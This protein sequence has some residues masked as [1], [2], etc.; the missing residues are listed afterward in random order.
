M[1]TIQLVAGIGCVVAA[2]PVLA[3]GWKLSAWASATETYT[4]NVNFSARS[5]AESDFVTSISAGLNIAGEGGGKRLKLNGSVGLAQNLYIGRAQDNSFAPNAN[6]SAK[7]EA[8]ENFAFVDAQAFVSQTFQSPFGA[9][10]TNT[11]TATENRYTQQTYAVSP[12]IKGVFPSSNISYQ[13]RDDNYWTFAS[14][15]GDSSTNI[16]ST[17]ANNL[18]VSM[19]S[20]VN[21]WGWTLSYTR[22]YFDNGVRNDRDIAT[23][24]TTYNNLLGTLIYQIDPQLQLSLRAGFQSYKFVGPS[25]EE[26]RYGIGFQWSPTDRTQV[27]GFWDHTFYGSSYSLQISHRL[28]NA[29]LSAN[30]SR[31]LS[32]FPQL[33]LA[34]PAGA[35]VNQFLNA[36]FATRIPD[37][38]ERTQAVDQFLART[39]LPPTLASPVNFYATTLTLQEAANL[40]LVLLGMRN[41]VT[42]SVFYLKSEAISAQGNV[43]PPA[44]QF[45]ENNTQRGVGVNYGFSLAAQTNVGASASYSTTTGNTS[46]GPLANARSNNANASVNLNRQFGPKTSGSAGVG[47]SW[48]ETPGSAIAGNQSAL[49]IYATVTYTFF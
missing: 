33:A 21:P 16:P 38:A 35:T 12:Y 41:S 36:A 43:L 47:Y 14:G 27:G 30:L 45:G 49:N 31:G 19:N 48:S 28:P 29:A 20:P 24:S 17:Y 4:N 9:Q 13:L 10:P 2:T 25:L 37:P 22:S 34:I 46:T 8:I 3:E 42:L 32:S 6:L 44:L 11:V 26:G 23:D 18:S 7:L 39:Q 40:S 15:F 1:A 5:E